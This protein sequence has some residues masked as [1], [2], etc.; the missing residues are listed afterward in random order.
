MCGVLSLCG[1]TASG[2]DRPA[3]RAG[4]PDGLGE[5]LA[6]GRLIEGGTPHRLIHFTF[7]D[8]P[9]P[10]NT[11]RLLDA[12]DEAGIKATFFFSASRFESG[13]RRNEGSVELAREVLARG[14]QVGSHSVDHVKMWK[15]SPEELRAQLDKSA[16]LFEEVFGKRTWLFRPPYGARSSRVDRML[17]E[18]GYTTVLWNIGLADWVERPPEALLETWHKVLARRER[19]DGER[20]GVVLLHDTHA[21][22]VEAFSLIYE[23]IQRRNCELL[24]AGEELYDVVDDLSLFHQARGEAPPGKAAGPAV[25]ARARLQKR[26]ARLRAQ[27]AV[28]CAADEAEPAESSEAAL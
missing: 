10:E 3:E 21:W 4:E 5:R 17:A 2:V 26:Q 11:P 28:R 1:W 9:D 22:T 25:P 27:A 7:D 13:A 23:D 15:L 18:R 8:G 14:H 6:R 19:E 16:R 20:G 24:A 12:L